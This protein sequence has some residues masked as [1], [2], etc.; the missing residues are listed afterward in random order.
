MEAEFLHQDMPVEM[1]VERNEGI[2]YLVIIGKDF[3]EK[4][5]ILLGNSMYGNVDSDLLSL[6]LLAIYLIN[7]C[8][9]T[10]I[11]ADSFVFS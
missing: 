1:L 9:M 6:I 4:Y 3:M 5:F 8:N 11:R 10:I 7:E 2:V